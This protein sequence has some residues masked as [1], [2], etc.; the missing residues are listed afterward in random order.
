LPEKN[1]VTG[2]K[3]TNEFEES[4]KFVLPGYNVRPLEMSGAIGVEQLK[5]LPDFIQQRK[6][7]A[8]QFINLFK[9]HKDFIIQKEIGQSSWFGFSLIIKPSSKLKSKEVIDQLEKN[10]IECRPIVTGNFATKEVMKFFDYEIFETLPNAD[11]V[12]QNG[13]FVGNHQIPLDKQ[14]KYLFDILK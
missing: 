13:L 6:K 10:N 5:K 4:F 7:N 2:K 11:Y 9:D 12:D 14:I 3:S 8:N 1:H